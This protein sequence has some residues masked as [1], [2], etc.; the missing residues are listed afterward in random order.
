MHWNRKEDR[1]YQ[2]LESRKKEILF[3]EYKLSFWQDGKSFGHLLPNNVNYLT[4]MRYTL[5]NGYFYLSSV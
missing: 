3:G 5:Q 1:T 4:H 2:G